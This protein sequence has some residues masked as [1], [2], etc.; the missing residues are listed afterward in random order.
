MGSERTWLSKMGDIGHDTPERRAR[1]IALLDADLHGL[2]QIKEVSEEIQ[3]KISV[4]R[5]RSISKLSTIADDRAGIRNFCTNRL[6]LHAVNDMVDVASVVDAWE[7]STTRM[8]VRHNAEAEASLASIPRAVPKVE[9]QDLLI[10]FET[11]HG[12]RL[13]D[14]TTPATSTLEL[15]F[16]QIEAGELKQMSLTQ[17]VSKEDSESEIIGATIERST[18]AIKVRKGYGECPKPKSPEELR[19]RMAVLANCYLL[20]QLK[21]PRKRC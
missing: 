11:L 18:G 14:K 17:M 12:Y 2:L 7:A 4:E 16:D 5:V 1:A 15:I 6:A 19:R 21:F 20:G 13:D 10:R 3:A 9:V 8:K